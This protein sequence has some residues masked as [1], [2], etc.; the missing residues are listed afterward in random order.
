MRSFAMVSALAAASIVSAGPTPTE[1][2]LPKRT[3][4]LPTVTVS[5]NGKNPWFTPSR[6]KKS[7][8]DG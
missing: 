1:K 8:D 6:Y 4:S 3:S 2:E 7:T 5:G